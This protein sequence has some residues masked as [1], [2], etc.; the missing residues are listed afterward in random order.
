MSARGFDP[1]QPLRRPV[2]GPAPLSERYVWS[3]AE[4]DRLERA[5][6]CGGPRSSPF[7]AAVA[8]DALLE[9]AELVDLL[10]ASGCD[11]LVVDFDTLGG[12]AAHGETPHATSLGLLAEGFVAETCSTSSTAAFRL[13]A[14]D[15]NPGARSRDGFHHGLLAD[16]RPIALAG[17]VR[18]LQRR[19]FAVHGIFTLGQDHDELGCFERL[20]T[21]VEAQGLVSVELRLWTPDPGSSVVRALAR[22]DRVRHRALER[23]DGAHV[24]VAP[25]QMSAQTLYRGWAWAQRRLDSP[26][27][28]WRRRP[29]ERLALRRY[30]RALLAAKLAPAWA[31]TRVRERLLPAFAS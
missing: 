9:A 27:S 20:V 25:K 19:G 4:L 24:V 10:A 16:S 29:R 6:T 23:W 7:A 5:L 11:E 13:R 15:E 17:L 18:Q 21:W 3:R 28:I 12:P 8:A 30:L 1:E 31:R 22:E 14:L 2:R 26:A